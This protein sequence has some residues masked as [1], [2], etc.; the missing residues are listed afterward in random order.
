MSQFLA[1]RPQSS[2][3][4]AGQDGREMTSREVSLES[5][6]AIM[7]NLDLMEERVTST[8]QRMRRDLSQ[9]ATTL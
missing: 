7:I 3:T 9:L 2:Q 8:I 5:L 4:S 1:T 6:S